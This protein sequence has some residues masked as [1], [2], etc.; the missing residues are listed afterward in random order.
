MLGPAPPTGPTTTPIAPAPPPAVPSTSASQALPAVAEYLRREYAIRLQRIERVRTLACGT[1]YRHCTEEKNIDS[2]C[3]ALGINLSARHLNIVQVA[4]GIAISF[5]DVVEVA[6]LKK[7]TFAATRTNV[8]KARN[9]RRQVAA[10]LRRRAETHWV[11]L[12]DADAADH[13]ELTC[14][15][16]QFDAL[17]GENDIDEAFL[18]DGT[19]SAKAVAIHMTYEGFKSATARVL[20]RLA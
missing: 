4:G 2:I 1:G 3:T 14:F 18:S 15:G 20:S 9:A 8:A 16:E 10:L 19:G 7:A 6:G 11:P 17:L 5:D 13:A 12:D